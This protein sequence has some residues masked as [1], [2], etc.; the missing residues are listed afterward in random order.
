MPH[1]SVYALQKLA[2]HQGFLHK[3]QPLASVWLKLSIHIGSWLSA[4]CPLTLIEAISRQTK[5]E[6]K[7]R[8]ALRQPSTVTPTKDNKRTAHRGKPRTA[9]R[10]K[11]WLRTQSCH[12]NITI[13]TFY[14]RII[15]SR[16]GRW[17]TIVH[18]RKWRRRKWRTN[19]SQ[20][21]SIKSLCLL[22]MT[23]ELSFQIEWRP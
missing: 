4:D 12:W 16:A 23:N 14:K 8:C 3:H 6:I 21:K 1:E 22:M 13:A 15:P 11:P 20:R 18:E 17:I 19:C 9:H 2:T 7:H 10:D 5:S